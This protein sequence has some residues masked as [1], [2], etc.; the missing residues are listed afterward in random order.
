[1][2]LL[3]VNSELHAQSSVLASGN[4]HKI[5]VDKQG[6][7]KIN[8]DLLKS[9]GVDVDNI[10]PKHLQL[11]GNGGKVLP[12]SNN[13]ARPVDLIQ[14]AIQ[15]FGENDG[16]FDS[17][18]YILFYAT[19]IDSTYFDLNTGSFIYKNH[20]YEKRAYYFLTV[21]NIAG[22][23]VV[24]ETDQGNSFSKINAYNFYEIYEEDKINLLSSGREWYGDRFDIITNH[25]YS[26]NM[27]NIDP[28]GSI[29]ITSSVMAQSY[30]TSSF[31]I[32][33]NSVKVGNQQIA[34]I[35]DYQYGLRGRNDTDT[36]EVVPSQVNHNGSQW[37]VNLL[38]HKNDSDKS[39]GYTNYIIFQ[40]QRLLLFNDQQFNFRSL[41][42][43]EYPFSTFEITGMTNNHQV[44]D[45]TIPSAPK[46]QEYS[47]LRSTATYGTP[48]MEL[49]E[50]VAF[51]PEET[52]LPESIDNIPNQ[53]LRGASSPEVLVITSSD[54]I[55]EARRLANFR[56]QHDGFKVLVVTTDQ[57]FNEF[58]SGSKDPSAIR[59]LAKYYYDQGTLKHLLLFGKC[60]YDFKDVNNNNKNYVPSY[61]S[62]NSLHPLK[63]Y[64][65]DDYFGFLEIEEGDWVEDT[66]G[67]HTLDIGV[68]R[69]PITTVQ[70][71]KDIVNKLIRYDTHSSTFGNWRNTLLFIADDGELTA[72]LH[73]KQADELAIFTN[74]NYPTFH[75]KK[76]FL[77]SYKQVSTASGVVAPIINRVIDSAIDEGALIVNYIGHGSENVWA[78]ERIL[79]LSMINSWANKYRLPLFVTA[80]CEFGRHDDSGNVSGAERTILNP[81]GGGIA[82]V[83]TGRPV[84]SGSNFKLNKAFYKSVLKKIENRYPTIGE[85]FMDT[86]NNSLNGS[87][88]RNFS[89]LGD[90]SM[91]LAY[92]EKEVIIDQVTTSSGEVNLLKA[93]SKV[94]LRGHINNTPNFEGTAKITVFDKQ[95]P[96]QTLGNENPVYKYKEW[97]N[98]L[99]Q[100]YSTI[101]NGSF[102]SEFVLPKSINYELDHGKIIIYALDNKQQADGSGAT[103]DILIGGSAEVHSLDEDA[104]EIFLY[105][106]D[107]TSQDK[108]IG[109]NIL[110]LAKL[111]DNNGINISNYGVG[112]GIVAVLDDSLSFDISQYYNASKDTYQTGWV[113]F[114]INDLTTGKHSITVNAADPYNNSTSETIR[115]YVNASKLIISKLFNYPNPVN[116]KTTFAFSHNFSGD[117]LQ[118]YLTLYKPNGEV[119]MN[120]IFNIANADERVELMEWDI[121]NEYGEKMTPGIYIYG[122]EVYSLSKRVKNKKFQKLIITN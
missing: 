115:F 54:F 66:F 57:V 120:H 19:N 122:I 41:K 96:F 50:F 27:P 36:F 40:A 62:R 29:K 92:P 9:K 86:K 39:I 37:S 63:T 73:H 12:Q 99:F 79:D 23:R 111:T 65:S 80:T 83:T 53:N 59:D 11:Y 52:Y 14:N 13:T 72:S 110:L 30:A 78:Q 44:W 114:P 98:I 56:S 34:E 68:G 47:L 119:I 28:N 48:T 1:M 105:L 70:Q 117:H 84:N 4:W 42:S 21:G 89:L 116:A 33:L 67:D 20:P 32:F 102:S 3:A 35:T 6:V 69:L 49:K 95:V 75:T 46:I 94:K 38:Y 10:N 82:I 17:S 71:A 45:V 97:D 100:G 90:P 55:N 25:S 103:T 113:L 107:T 7:Y 76:I 5:T 8:Y 18:D 31:D 64:S 43:L 58:S 121:Y 88:N 91:T 93:L 16:S 22:T 87:S 26:F 81:N 74:T 112:G 101:S 51:S 104:P 108:I 106:N 2:L 15:V 77:D 109:S 60:S 24:S 118:I 85:V 61:P